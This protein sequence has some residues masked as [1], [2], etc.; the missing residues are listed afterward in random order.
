MGEFKYDGWCSGDGCANRRK[1]MKEKESTARKLAGAI[2]FALCAIICLIF[3]GMAAE[4]AANAA[5]VNKRFS[6]GSFANAYD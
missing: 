1:G 4:R 2:G 3:G 6:L 5:A